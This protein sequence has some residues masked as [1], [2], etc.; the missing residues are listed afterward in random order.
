MGRSSIIVKKKRREA[1]LSH[2]LLGETLEQITKAVNKENGWDWHEDT[3]YNDTEWIRS[4]YDFSKDDKITAIYSQFMGRSHEISRK[5]FRDLQEADKRVVSTGNDLEA[6]YKSKKKPSVFD[7]LELEQYKEDELTLL[8]KLQTA[9][10]DKRAALYALEKHDQRFFENLVKIG[11][12][13]AAPQETVNVNVDINPEEYIK[14]YVIAELKPKG[15]QN[16]S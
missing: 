3:I 9:K 6:F 16:K 14:R 7:E 12:I 5:A 8:M 1:V 15:L 11:A 2:W 13:K 4:Q 10:A